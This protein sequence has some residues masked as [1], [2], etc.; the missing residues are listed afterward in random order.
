MQTLELAV[1]GLQTKIKKPV[2]VFDLETTHADATLCEII[3][4]AGV[5]IP[6]TGPATSLVFLA[7]PNVPCTPEAEVVHGITNERLVNEPGFEHYM[8]QIVELFTGADVAGY[9]AIGF[10]LQILERY[11]VK[12]GHSTLLD[13]AHV[14]DAFTLFAKQYPRTLTK[15][16]ELYAGDEM[17]DAHDAMADV[18]ATIMVLNAQIDREGKPFTA[19]SEATHMAPDRR[20]GFTDHIIIDDTGTPVINFGK[21]KGTP[22]GFVPYDFKQ[23]MLRNS[24]PPKIKEYIRG[25][26]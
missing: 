15:A 17:Q 11:L 7:K 22:I 4:F 16:F 10:D 8:P 23:W 5:R 1:E 12:M 19:V 24:F 21:H 9:N 3:Q 20:V 6:P 26:A 25:K 18:A 14:L 2:V 13:D